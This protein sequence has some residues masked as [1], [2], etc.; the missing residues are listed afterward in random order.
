MHSYQSIGLKMADLRT[1]G[2]LITAVWG[3]FGI[4]LELTNKIYDN[5]RLT[6]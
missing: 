5:A 4:W 2:Q 3:K 6:F 1:E